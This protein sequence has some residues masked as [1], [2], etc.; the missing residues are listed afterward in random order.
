MMEIGGTLAVWLIPLLCGLGIIGIEWKWKYPHIHVVDFFRADSFS[1]G[2]SLLCI[3][4]IL[5]PLGWWIAIPAGAIGMGVRAIASEDSR[6]MWPT[7][8]QARSAMVVAI[9]AGVIISGFGGVSEPTGAAEWGTPL[10][11]ENPDAPNWP[12]SEQHIWNDGAAILVVNHVRLPGTLSAIGSGSMV[13]WHLESSGT[14]EVRLKQAMEQ[15]EGIGLNA[16]WFTL[17][18][19]AHGQSY[20]YEGGT[21]P[22]TLK[23]VEI[24]GN[25][26]A[27]MITVAIGV[28]GGEVHLL[29]IIKPNLPGSEFLPFE[30]DPYAS[31]YVEPW[32]AANA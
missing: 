26:I 25:K 28:W 1:Q 16:D 31:Q 6:K 10:Q 27:E 9:V 5:V 11:T 18:T 19:T 13:L 2:L 20:D 12:A 7:R 22:Y 30:S 21:L 24:S 29:T 15:L 3:G 23:H 14:D 4:I 17:E 32:L 8:W